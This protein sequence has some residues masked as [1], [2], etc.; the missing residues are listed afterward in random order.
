MITWKHASS[1]EEREHV[2]ALRA[3]EY[4]RHYANVTPEAFRDELD[5]ALLPNG[6]RQSIVVLAEQDG[7]PAGTAR[8][9]I[10]R[11]PHYPGLACECHEMMDFD[12]DA[13]VG[14]AGFD[15]KVAV[16]GETGRLA[17]GRGGD[18]SAVKRCVFSQAGDA[19]S[20]LGI[21]VILA[22]MSPFVARRVC[23]GGVPF[24]RWPVAQLRRNHLEEVRTLLCYHD[25]FLPM[26]R[27]HGLEI[28]PQRLE[29][30][31]NLSA[32]QALIAD[33]PDGTYLWYARTDEWVKNVK[34]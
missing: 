34:R 27:Q 11:H 3:A 21:D 24:V 32:L 12:F 22:M 6:Q 29:A 26:I 28:D 4:S 33:S 17:I 19:G 25:Y 30:T 16:V 31:A 9:S 14:E 15:P 8:V 1:P 5:S 10:S 20:L 7:R 18:V 23:E 2:Y 13:L